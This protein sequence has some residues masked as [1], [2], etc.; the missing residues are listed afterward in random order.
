MTTVWLSSDERRLQDV[1][2]DVHAERR[3]QT[4]LRDAGRMERLAA[5][6]EEVGEV[7]RAL[8]ERDGAVNDVHGAKLRTELVQVAAVAVAW[9]EYLDAE[10]KR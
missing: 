8:L 1:L 10:A 9:I 2:S 3:R 5:L 4:S 6:V 7:G